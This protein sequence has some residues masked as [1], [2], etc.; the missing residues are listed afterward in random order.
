[1]QLRED[2]YRWLE[3]SNPLL[4]WNS[5]DRKK[6]LK[7]PCFLQI[8]ANTE[9]LI[10][11]GVDSYFYKGALEK[12]IKVILIEEDIEKIGTFLLDP[13]F[14]PHKNLYLSTN[15]REQIL[16]ILKKFAFK[17]VQ[18]G[19]ALVEVSSYIDGIFLSY[20]EY[21]DLGEQILPNILSNILHIFK[22]ID[23]RDFTNALVNED[24]IVT[25]SGI[26]LSKA[27]D[28][29][30]GMK[31]R[32]YIL[33]VGSSLP[34]LIDA[35][36][37]PDFYAV[38]DPS[39]PLEIYECLKDLSIPL[40]YQNRCSRDILFL[41]KGP[42]VFMGTSKG[43]EI[44]DALIKQI[45]GKNFSF[46]AGF[47]A[48]N[49]G[50]HI[51]LALGAKRVFLV[52]MDGVSKAKET[53]NLKKEGFITRK[54]LYYGMDFFKTLKEEFSDQ[55]MFHYTQGFAFDEDCKIVNLDVEP[56]K[57]MIKLPKE[58]IFDQ[59]HIKHQIDLFFDHNMLVSL[60]DFFNKIEKEP[61]MVL[62][63]ASCIEAEFSLE[64]F[65]LHF[66][67]PLWEIWKHMLEESE[68][69]LCKLTFYYNILKKFSEKTG[70]LA[71]NFYIFGKKEGFYLL[72]NKNNT[73]CE[74]GFYFKG[75]L[76]GEF[77][78][79]GSKGELV[80]LASM[81][82]GQRDGKYQ[83]Y[84]NS[85]LIREG[86][87]Y[88]GKPDGDHLYYE[89]GKVLDQISYSKG[90]KIGVHKYFDSMN[91]KIEEIVYKE[92]GFYNKFEYDQDGIVKYSGVWQGDIFYEDSYQE[93]QKIYSR[94]GKIKNGKMIFQ[95]ENI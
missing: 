27:I 84:R 42:K 70:F 11:E 54:D 95:E 39:P 12:G 56:K 58:K 92:G 21:K 4:L 73:I 37:I 13:N 68:E 89:N 53:V 78:Q 75:E 51:A 31:K 63:Y 85:I 2:V 65:Y 23:G 77:K 25:G 26:S 30:K 82:K 93:G 64:P 28:E 44:E 67:A 41:H 6:E 20:S 22:Y 69:I 35:G 18:K 91:R 1:M 62:I 45:G 14:S 79:Y 52:G 49:F 47:N 16:P 3:G 10:L 71:G 43:W 15:Q 46:D 17:K 60:A 9:V 7:E 66:I 48:G 40:F 72:K 19:G 24:V 50:A 61:S 38:V 5:F 87:F 81:D 80:L 55:Q 8:F 90:E 33:A 74:E 88:K 94:M 57:G 34:I 86:Y 29:I 59:E 36:I 32:P 76:Y 83:I